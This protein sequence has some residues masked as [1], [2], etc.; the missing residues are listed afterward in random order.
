[1]VDIIT[2]K[3]PAGDAEPEETVRFLDETKKATNSLATDIA[4]ITARIDTLLV[5][6][7]WHIVGDPGEPV[8]ENLWT[9]YTASSKF[10]VASFY[11]DHLGTVHL[12]GL[13][14]VTSG[15]GVGTVMFTLPIGYRPEK[16]LIVAQIGDSALVRLDVRVD[17]SV[18]LAVGAGAGSLSIEGISFLAV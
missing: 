17:G 8:F 16:Q 7:A 4:T 13:V 2:I 18:L 10:N 1:M 6:E 15:T 12:K 14:V 9:N 5:P 11:K 3:T